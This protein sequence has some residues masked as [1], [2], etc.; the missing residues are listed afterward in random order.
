ML[1]MGGGVTAASFEIANDQSR[2]I[3][4]SPKNKVALN[5]AQEQTRPKDPNKEYLSL[6]N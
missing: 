2:R 6:N 4:I 3:S 1:Q 5:R